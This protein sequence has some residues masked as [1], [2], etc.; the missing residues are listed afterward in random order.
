MLTLQTEAIRG[1]LRI[2]T[3]PDYPS[4]KPQIPRHTAS[5]PAKLYVRHQGRFGAQPR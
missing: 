3:Q 1:Q 5:R 2:I 4:R